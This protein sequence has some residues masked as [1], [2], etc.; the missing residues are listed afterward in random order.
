LTFPT[1]VSLTANVKYALVFTR[2]GS[3]SSSN[4]IFLANSLT[5][6]Y[7]G[8]A[9]LQYISGSWTTQSGDDIY[10]SFDVIVEATVDTPAS[11]PTVSAELE[12]AF[13]FF[14]IFVIF[15]SVLLFV[16]YIVR[17]IL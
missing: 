8:G 5:D 12:W 11:T 2:S 4:F 16:M 13:E 9:Y 17:K 15:G 7:P 14:I 1:P 3:N 6:T 10:G